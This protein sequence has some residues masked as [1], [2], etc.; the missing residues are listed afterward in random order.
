MRI[1]ME[2]SGEIEYLSVGVALKPEWTALSTGSTMRTSST[3]LCLSEYVALASRHSFSAI[4]TCESSSSSVRGCCAGKSKSASVSL[5]EN[6]T[7]LFT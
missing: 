2:N 3:T 6:Q 1:V 5:F 7:D 4:F